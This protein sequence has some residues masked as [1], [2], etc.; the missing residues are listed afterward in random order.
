MKITID[1]ITPYYHDVTTK[2]SSEAEF[3]CNSVFKVDFTAHYGNKKMNGKT[4]MCLELDLAKIE[5]SILTDIKN[6][7]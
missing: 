5:D 2:E 4:N 3:I 7:C 1:S 6:K